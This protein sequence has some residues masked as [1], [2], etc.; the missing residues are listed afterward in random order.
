MELGSDSPG[1][2]SSARARRSR[3]RPQG[4]GPAAGLGTGDIAQ[5]VGRNLALEVPPSLCKRSARAL[6]PDLE[7]HPLERPNR[8]LRRHRVVG[9]LFDRAAIVW[10]VGAVLAEQHHEWLL[11]VAT[12]AAESLKVA[13]DGRLEQG[14]R[15]GVCHERSPLAS[16]ASLH[17]IRYNPFTL[18]GDLDET[19]V[20]SRFAIP[21]EEKHLMR[22][23]FDC[24]GAHPA[25]LGRPPEVGGARG[26]SP[27]RHGEPEDAA[28]RYTIQSLAPVCLPSPAWLIFSRSRNADAL[29][30]HASTPWIPRCRWSVPAAAPR[31]FPP[32]HGSAALC[33]ESATL[34]CADP[35]ETTAS[36]TDGGGRPEGPRGSPRHR[37]IAA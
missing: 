14:R 16:V 21:D 36:K 18:F 25:E 17:P 35:G 19:D 23:A 33:S 20:A 2:R 15:G 12:P 34:S 13:P 29:W 9:I 4:R 22:R 3:A 26:D 8:E 6:A 1:I 28:R 27:L 5:H 31:Q 24:V 11:H 30:L 7:Q 32:H 10:L 37:R